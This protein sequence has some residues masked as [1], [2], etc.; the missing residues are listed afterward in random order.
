MKRE[1]EKKRGRRKPGK[2]NGKGGRKRER[3]REQRRKERKE[4]KGNGEKEGVK[5]IRMISKKEGKNCTGNLTNK[6]RTFETHLNLFWVYSLL[7][8]WRE[9]F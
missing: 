6:Q 8:F 1:K 9:I 3:E 7:K 5:G 4:E 2:G